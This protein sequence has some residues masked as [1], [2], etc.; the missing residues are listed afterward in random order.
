MK[1][2]YRRKLTAYRPLRP[3]WMTLMGS[4]DRL[5]KSLEDSLKNLAKR[6]GMEPVSPKDGQLWFDLSK[7]LVMRYSG[8]E[9]RWVKVGHD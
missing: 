5:A 9:Q 2:R 3:A 1:M 8:S 6:L 7:G 4:L